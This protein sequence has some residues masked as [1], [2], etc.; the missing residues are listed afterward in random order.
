MGAKKVPGSVTLLQPSWQRSP[1]TAPILRRPSATR[2]GGDAQR[3]RRRLK[4]REVGRDGAAAEV[5]AVAEER[6]AAVRVVR[7]L[8][9]VERDDVLELATVDAVGAEQDV[10][11]NVGAVPHDAPRADDRR[12][13]HESAR[14]NHRVGAEMDGAAR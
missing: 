2:A 14:L 13:A 9:A 3:R 8:A 10:A 7:Q 5:G 4:Q 11:S 12:P 6:V 1:R